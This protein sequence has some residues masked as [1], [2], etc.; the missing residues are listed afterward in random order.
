LMFATMSPDEAAVLVGRVKASENDRYAMG[1]LVKDARS[2]E[3]RHWLEAEM[4]KR[5]RSDDSDEGAGGSLAKI[6]PDKPKPVTPATPARK[7]HASYPKGK[8][9]S[10][11]LGRKS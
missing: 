3:L 6:G 11:Q 4:K 8:A 7:I 1:E 10:K 9:A 2:G 5:L